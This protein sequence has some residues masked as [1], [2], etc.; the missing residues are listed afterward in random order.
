LSRT[1][2]LDKRQPASRRR[3]SDLGFCKELRELDDKGEFQEAKSFK[4]KS[5]KARNW[6]RVAW[7]HLSWMGSK[8]RRSG[9]QMSYSTEQSGGDVSR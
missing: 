2:L 7:R 1:R 4:E 9:S 8:K 6:G 3:D 5:P